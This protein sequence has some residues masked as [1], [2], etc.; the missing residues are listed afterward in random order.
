MFVPRGSRTARGRKGGVSGTQRKRAR[1]GSRGPGLLRGSRSSRVRGSEH[2][3]R[4]GD[5]PQ[6]SCCECFWCALPPPPKMGHGEKRKS[7][8]PGAAAGK[9]QRLVFEYPAVIT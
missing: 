2:L 8:T 9:N 1:G 3:P 7:R 6:A 5:P 4:R